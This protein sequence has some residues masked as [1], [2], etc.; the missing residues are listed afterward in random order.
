MPPGSGGLGGLPRLLAA[1]SGS[2]FGGD[3]PVLGD[4]R[5]GFGGGDGAAVGVADDVGHAAVHD[6]PGTLGEVRSDDAEGAEVVL[7]ALDHLHVVEASELGVLL[8]GVIS[9]ADQRGAQ[10]RR[11]GLG[12]GLALW[13]GVTVLAVVVV[14]GRES[15]SQ[16]T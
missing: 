8:A 15:G 11:P 9:G 5:F 12:H 7:A 2:D 16:M 10:Q 13:V 4:D 6:R 3:G 14:R 1:A